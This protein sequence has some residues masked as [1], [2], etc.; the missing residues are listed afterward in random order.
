MSASSSGSEAPTR[1]GMILAGCTLLGRQVKPRL[2]LHATST[3][4]V[5]EQGE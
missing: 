4:V 3:C 1:F 5:S 2:T